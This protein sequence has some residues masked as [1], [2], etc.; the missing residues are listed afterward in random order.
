METW[1]TRA[2]IILYRVPSY[3]YENN[4][5]Y[6]IITNFVVSTGIRLANYKHIEYVCEHS[7]VAFHQGKR[8]RHGFSPSADHFGTASFLSKCLVQSHASFFSPFLYCNGLF[9]RRL[10]SIRCTTGTFFPNDC[11][12]TKIIRQYLSDMTYG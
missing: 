2:W 10:C 4:F 12:R 9:G 8:V 5:S 3:I 6:Y 7:S 1:N 11:F